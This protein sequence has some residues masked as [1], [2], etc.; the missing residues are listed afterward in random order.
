MRTAIS[1]NHGMGWGLVRDGKAL[2]FY[3]A[4]VVVS[5]LHRED[6]LYDL[7]YTVTLLKCRSV[8]Y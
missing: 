1:A 8:E 2:S 7:F 3:L 6:T 4:N 5:M